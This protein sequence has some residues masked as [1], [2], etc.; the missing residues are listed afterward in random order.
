MLQEFK[1]FALKGNV[2]DLAVGMVIG[3]AFGKIV[4]SLVE[5]IIMPVMGFIT[6]RINISALA[7]AVRTGSNGTVDFSIRY[8]KFLQSALDF[9]LI[10]F[11]IFIVI[12]AINRF[13]Q[14]NETPPAPVAETTKT[15]LL[16]T[17]IRDLLK[18]T[19]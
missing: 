3:S 2:I 9:V 13:R 4:S 17:E 12:K 8:G 16:L 7:L 14:K 15:D 5:D 6:G 11:S 1:K 18:Q 19:K 10:A